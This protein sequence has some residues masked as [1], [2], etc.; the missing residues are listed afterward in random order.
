[1]RR[2]QNPE[3]FIDSTR[4][5]TSNTNNTN[6]TNNYIFRKQYISVTINVDH[7]KPDAYGRGCSYD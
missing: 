7:L 2:H 3:N 5:N 6:N 4:E 1:M